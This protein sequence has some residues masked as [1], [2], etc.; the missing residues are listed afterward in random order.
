MEHFWKVIYE[1][2]KECFIA[3]GEWKDYCGEDQK[4]RKFVAARIKAAY[5]R[6]EK[7]KQAI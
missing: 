6:R 1:T 3:D 5:E 7:L 4:L 2:L